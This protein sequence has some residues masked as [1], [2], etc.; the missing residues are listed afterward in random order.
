MPDW[1]Y[2][3]KDGNLLIEVWDNTLDSYYTGGSGG[4]IVSVYGF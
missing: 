1:C 2:I 4:R 3:Q